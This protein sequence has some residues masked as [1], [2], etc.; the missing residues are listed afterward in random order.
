[1]TSL[2]FDV[3]RVCENFID[4]FVRLCLPRGKGVSNISYESARPDAPIAIN[5]DSPLLGLLQVTVRI[6]CGDL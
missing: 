2:Q 3:L 4:S 5:N 1:M 6:F